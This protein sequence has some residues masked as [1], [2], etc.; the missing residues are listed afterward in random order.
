MARMYP[1][2]YIVF[3][4]FRAPV[5]LQLT[6]PKEVKPESRCLSHRSC[7]HLLRGVIR[8]RLR[9]KYRHKE[10]RSLHNAN[11]YRTHGRL[12]MRPIAAIVLLTIGYV[13]AFSKAVWIDTD[14]SVQKG[15]HEVDDGFALVQ[16]FR[17]NEL[18]IRGISVVFGNSPLAEA[19]PIG[20]DLV[21]RYG[22]PKMPVYRGAAG[23]AELGIETPASR[24]LAD[25]LKKERLTI[26]VLAPA[27]NVATVVKND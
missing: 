16:A 3:G 17:S 6:D 1:E 18:A 26:L 2:L 13:P 4:S 9:Y 12:A 11:R 14:P 20:Q 23:A 5:F 10:S 21:K 25:A 15:V 7:Y 22:P 19:Y 27:T 24:A 8:W